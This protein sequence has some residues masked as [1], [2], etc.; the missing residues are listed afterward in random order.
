MRTKPRVARREITI[1]ELRA[2]LGEWEAAHPGFG[3]D[4]FPD[5]FRDEHGKLIETDEF[6]DLCGWYSLLRMAERAD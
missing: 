6:Q 5:A 4:N 1:E 2:R 3:K